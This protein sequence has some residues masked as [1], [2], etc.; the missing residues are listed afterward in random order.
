VVS[1]GESGLLVRER[2]PEALAQAIT[3]LR[4]NP[5]H[6]TSLARTGATRA[7]ER[8]SP[9]HVAR[10]YADIYRDAIGSAAH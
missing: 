6:G 5:D 9:D 8:F 4:A 7:R 3:R 2:T 10:R 1:D